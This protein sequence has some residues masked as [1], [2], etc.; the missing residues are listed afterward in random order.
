MSTATI[1]SVPP[2]ILQRLEAEHSAEQDAARA[3]AISELAQVQTDLADSAPRLT[4]AVR[5]AESAYEAAKIKAAELIKAAE[6]KLM[7]AR[8]DRH[9]KV[10]PLERRRDQLQAELQGSLRHPSIAAALEKIED[11]RE[12][13]RKGDD[14]KRQGSIIVWCDSARQELIDLQF[15]LADDIPAAVEAIMDTQP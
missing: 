14:F 4:D 5:A 3:T 2:S 6:T 10:Y 13:T 11:L 7:A 1:S 12:Q 15:S 8:H 9:T